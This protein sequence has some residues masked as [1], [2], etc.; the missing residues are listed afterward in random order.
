MNGWQRLGI[1]IGTLIA[2]PSALI[3]YSE[4]D[5]AFV[6][7]YPSPKTWK[8]EGQVFSNKVYWDAVDSHPELQGCV[9]ET[10]DVERSYSGTSVFVTCDR[11]PMHVI[12]DVFWW[13]LLPYLV[14][15]G[16]GYTCSWVYRGFRPRST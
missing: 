1:V 5:S 12:D 11:Q 15:F 16:I 9:L 7:V 2:A 3:G 6:T 8:L 14:V 13:A 10:A 4:N